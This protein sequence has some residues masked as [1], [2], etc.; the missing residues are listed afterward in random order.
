MFSTVITKYILRLLVGITLAAG[1]ISCGEEEVDPTIQDKV[2]DG[3][4][5]FKSGN[6]ASALETFKQ[7][8]LELIKDGKRLPNAELALGWGYYRL[9]QPDSAVKYLTMCMNDEKEAI[10]PYSFIELYDLD[11][12]VDHA[13]MPTSDMLA[14]LKTFLT[15]ERPS[16]VFQYDNSINH[17]D[18]ALTGAQ[19]QFKLKDYA[20][21]VEF[22]QLIDKSF[23]PDPESQDYV[24]Q[25]LDKLDTLVAANG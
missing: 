5:Q 12:T 22:I 23:A 15:T 20:K 11:N 17:S 21:S 16:Y 8:Y 9:N 6:Y 13:I 25:I 4:A 1:I 3:W 24:K 2:D 10:I 14:K 19:I 18:G 7:A